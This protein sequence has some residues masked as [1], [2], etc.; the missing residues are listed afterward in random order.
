MD[1][2]FENVSTDVGERWGVN[3]SQLQVLLNHPP[4]RRLLATEQSRIEQV[5][6]CV[7]ENSHL[8]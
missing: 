8:I 2:E 4:A 3:M 6:F 5:P 1:P 7:G